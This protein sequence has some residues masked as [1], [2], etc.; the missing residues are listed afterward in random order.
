M[1]W[2]QFRDPLCYLCL[3]C[4]VVASWFLIQE[5]AGLNN[6]FK[7]NTF[8]TEFSKFSENIS[9]SACERHLRKHLRKF[10]LVLL[11]YVIVFTAD[12]LAFN[13]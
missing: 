4:T 13:E 7:Y 6:L 8:V 3:P 12:K 9:S 11:D 5:V 2:A 10:V 1:N